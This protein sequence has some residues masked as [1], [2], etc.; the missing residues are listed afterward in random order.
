MSNSINLSVGDDK[1]LRWVFEIK[2]AD[3]LA[4]LTGHTITLEITV[5]GTPTN[6]S[7]ALFEGDAGVYFDVPV[8]ITGVVKNNTYKIIDV[9]TDGDQITIESGSLNY[10]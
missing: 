1:P 7:G 9:D 2:G 3:N 4:I 10:S 6:V 5:D 8:G